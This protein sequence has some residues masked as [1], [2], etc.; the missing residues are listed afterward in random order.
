M[1]TTQYKAHTIHIV[2]YKYEQHDTIY[3]DYKLVQTSHQ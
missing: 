3:M 1:R 2:T